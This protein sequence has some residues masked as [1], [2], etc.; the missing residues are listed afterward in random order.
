MAVIKNQKENNTR[1]YSGV[2][3]EHLYTDDENVSLSSYYGNHYGGSAKI[4][5]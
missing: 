4:E 3:W 5:L 2:G 1:E